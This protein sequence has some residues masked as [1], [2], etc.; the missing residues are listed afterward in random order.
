MTWSF[1]AIIVRIGLLGKTQTQE[2][3]LTLSYF[4]AG[5]GH[6]F[7]STTFEWRNISGQQQG[8]DKFKKVSPNGGTQRQLPIFSAA[9]TLLGPVFL[10]HPLMLLKSRS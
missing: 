5:I 2:R 9:K 10:K 1:L 8:Y 6:P 3:I 7:C 4:L